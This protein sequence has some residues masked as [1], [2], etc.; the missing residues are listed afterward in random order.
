MR[1]TSVTPMKNEGPYIVEWVA[2]HRAI[3]INDIHVFTNDCSDGTDLILER[4]DE[5]SLLRHAPNP[6]VLVENPRHH[7]QLINYINHMPRLRRSD[8]VINLDADE[9]LS[10]NTGTGQ[11]TDLFAQLPDADAISISLREF[12]CN[13]TVG[14]AEN[15]AL[16]TDTFT[17]GRA[18][19]GELAAA[20]KSFIRGQAPGC[21]R[22]A[23]NSPVFNSA[24]LSRAKWYNADGERLLIDPGQMPVKALPPDRG[25]FELAHICHYAVR[26]M[27]G[28]LVQCDRGNAN[29]LKGVPDNGLKWN[30]ARR[31]FKKFD[32]NEV[33][34]RGLQTR[35]PD[36]RDRVQ[37]L[38]RDDELRRLHRA[39][40]DWHRQRSQE[41]LQDESYRSLLQA[42]KRIHKR[43]T[44]PPV[45]ACQNRAA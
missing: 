1:I 25:G 8:W 40:V 19:G 23:N 15:D 31:Y 3:G 27:H 17:R 7:I 41:L 6:S 43:H 35:C 10:I 38:L 33:E 45:A 37:A 36:L 30:K 5:M 12:G 24:G 16:V 44:R 34:D 14:I 42:M 11:V 18:P 9:F 28:Y 4:L 22:F 26:S 13:G 2:Y 32:T 29:P 39:S 21:T 20:I